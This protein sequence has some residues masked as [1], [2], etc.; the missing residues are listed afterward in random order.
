M[1]R[2]VSMNILYTLLGV[3]LLIHSVCGQG[4]IHLSNKQFIDEYGQPFFPMIMN[5]YVDFVYTDTLG[6]L[7]DFTNCYIARPSI[8]GATGGHDYANVV[9]GPTKILQD[10]YE[11]ANLG[12]NV[13]R[14]VMTPKKKDNT[15]FYLEVK[16][17]PSGQDYYYPSL[18]P[19]YDP[20]NNPALQFYFDQLLIIFSKAS[21]AGLKV[22]LICAD[23]G[24][25]DPSFGGGALVSGNVGDQ[26]IEDYYNYLSA[27]ADFIHD[28]DVHN[29]FAYEFHGE[30][31][32]SEE[33]LPTQHTKSEICEIAERWNSA[34]KMNDPVHL[35]TIG[36]VGLDD[37]FK[38]G[39]DPNLLSVDFANVHFYLKPQ[40]FEYDANQA[41][42]LE[43]EYKRYRDKFYIYCQAIKKP[44]VVAE[45]SFPGEN[46]SNLAFPIATYGDEAE[47]QTFL[48]E[49]FPLIRNTGA[50]GYGWWDFQNKH[51]YE[52]PPPVLQTLQEYS[53]N[54][55]GLLSYGDP[56]ENDLLN[57]YQ[58]TSVQ[59][60]KLAAE[61]FLYYKNN[62][63]TMPSNP[64]YGP[65]SPTVN[66][67]DP[68]Y[69]PYDHPFN[70]TVFNNH[71]GTLTGYVK[72]QYGQPVINAIVKG[73]SYV[74]VNNGDPVMYGY[75]T[76]TDQIGYF[77]LRAYDYDNLSSP[78]PNYHQDWT[79][80]DLKIAAYGSE[81]VQRGWYG[82]PISAFSNYTINS[83][84]Y[85]YDLVIDG[86]T[87]PIGIT[88]NFKG[89]SSLTA[90]NVTV[91][92]NGTQGG[93]SDFVA[94]N[95][96]HLKPGFNAEWGSE[97]HLFTEPVFVDCDDISTLG[98]RQGNSSTSTAVSIK[99]DIV[100]KAVEIN[101]FENKNVIEAAIYP[102]PNSGD[103]TLRLLGNVNESLLN[104]IIVTDCMGSNIMQQTF[105]GKQL[106][107]SFPSLKP[108]VYFIKIHSGGHTITRKFVII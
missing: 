12:F 84:Q 52:L 16:G 49:T 47:G 25:P 63:P 100:E 82:G 9:D 48:E 46:G 94:G 69:N 98:F 11:M 4:N 60:R 104:A 50:S 26:N 39:W 65:I 24:N 89:I 27:L 43:K 59:L 31:T 105:N 17:F 107:I 51:W 92:G 53:E 15:G 72:D 108:G 8:Y 102:N 68:F 73:T 7:P 41:T 21:T 3:I 78:Y 83:L 44:F 55:Y 32:Y 6:P 40:L 85:Q 42:F 61:K 37:P 54:F 90:L 79:I 29:L 23:P 19:P 96:V 34:V 71:Y 74:S 1:A 45:T 28:N 103:F 106:Q 66:M 64:D 97:V 35:T 5:Y 88:Q 56:D 95:E 93:V 22:M 38:G 86:V 13:V 57:G 30:P 2:T 75:Y 70:N 76:F 33:K 58:N 14:I 36:V 87:V 101:F 99:D 62:P 10:F 67:G 18:D 80:D 91:A 20:L 81:M 77:E